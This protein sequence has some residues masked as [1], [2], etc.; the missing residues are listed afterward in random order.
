M[1]KAYG[2]RLAAA[3]VV[4]FLAVAGICGIFY[5][6]KIFDIQILPLLQRVFIDFSI[7][8]ILL[9]A[10]VI[11]LTL[12]FGRFY[13]STLCPFGIIQEL[14]ALLFFSG[15]ESGKERGK[16]SGRKNKPTANYPVKYFIAA[17]VLGALTGG[18]ALLLRYIE[19]YTYFGSAF[20][21]SA[22]GL[23]G[24]LLVILLTGFK[25]R[26]FC[27]NICPA[28]ALLGLISKISL[29]KIYIDKNQCVSCGMCERNCPSGCI[30]SKE[31]TVDNVTCVKCLKCL[32]VCPK[33]GIKYGI[34]P[35]EET[36]F[37]LKRRELITGV[38]AAAVF[39]AMIKAGL[40]IKDKIVEKFKDII[41]PPGAES[42]ERFANKCY[43][44]NLCVANCP[45]KIIVKADKDFPAVHLDYSKGC[46]DKNCN[47]CGEVCPT[48]AIKRL[49]LEEKQKTRIGMAM[50]VEEKCGKC[51]DCI[52][53]CPYGA[54][55]RVE[56]K[57]I[58]NASKC[59]G[60]GACKQVCK[61]RGN[62]IEIF[63][64]RK[65]SLI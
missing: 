54:I 55:M 61:N 12:V 2:I 36:K 19:P 27:T 22:V 50:I 7:S 44:C 24:I 57:I 41:L 59:V 58:I 40:V 47:K 1:K 25:N 8:A 5:P 28:G 43:N 23:A 14:A 45:N 46:C 65:Q 51:G 4:L 35:K 37:S 29:N 13:C 60:C 30:N 38:A 32:S 11:L 63:A 62:A 21:I 16:N 56:D 10:G 26:F 15:K 33:G 64:V 52:A 53:A 42:E 17:V 48:G 20:T 31:K 18:S 6:V 49:K 39:G 3:F 34:K 9:L